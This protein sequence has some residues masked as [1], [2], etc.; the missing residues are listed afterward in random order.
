MHKI[1]LTPNTLFP[2][3]EFGF[4]QT[5]V[6]T[7]GKTIYCAGQTAWDI[8]K[9]IVGPGD[10][11]KQLQQTL[12]NV[13]LALEAAGAI[14]AD[15]V[16]ARIYIVDYKPEQIEIIAEAMCS[17][18]DKDNLPANTVLGVES[19]ALPEF[20]VEIEVTAVIAE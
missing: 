2:S 1:S 17:F 19:L 16:Q 10:L 7:G 13:R 8:N 6:S 14:P 12:E 20:L 9:Q 5:V 3:S 18:F 4:A 11:A 15:V